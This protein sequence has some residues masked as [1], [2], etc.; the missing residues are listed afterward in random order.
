MREPF[1]RR[2]LTSVFMFQR[3]AMRFYV[4][5]GYQRHGAMHVILIVFRQLQQHAA[6]LNNTR[7][8]HAF[9]TLTPYRNQSPTVT[10]AGAR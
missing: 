8:R 3:D 6:L 7:C 5:A 2:A 10:P 9:A 4:Y 1:T